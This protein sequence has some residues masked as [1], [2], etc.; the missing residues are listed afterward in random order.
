MKKDKQHLTPKKLAATHQKKSNVSETPKK[1]HLFT[2]QKNSGFLLTPKFFLVLI[3]YFQKKSFK[4]AK[5]LKWQSQRQVCS[6]PCFTPLWKK[7]APN[8]WHMGSHT[9]G[10]FLHFFFMVGFTLKRNAK[11][12][13]S[14]I[15]GVI[16][17]LLLKRME[18]F[19]E[20]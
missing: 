9:F 3:C 4:K 5:Q 17:S 1:F 19:E 6:W 16:S 7:V 18:H 20:Y 11:M 2:L 10:A 8:W 15:N 12:Q 14:F 13:F